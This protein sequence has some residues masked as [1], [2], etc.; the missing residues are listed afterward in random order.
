MF[1]NRDEELSFLNERYV[2][3]STGELIVIYGRRRVG[4]TELVRKFIST[5]EKSLYLYIDYASPLEV[6]D[7]ISN[8]ISRQ[9]GDFVRFRDWDTFYSY[10]SSRGGVVVI[11][12]F[13]RLFEIDK[14][15]VTRLQRIWDIEL[16]DKPLML[17]LVGSSIGMMRNA[18]LSGTAPL[19]GRV[20][21]TM[22]LQPL[23][24]RSFRYFFPEMDEVKKVQLYA[25]FGGTP[26]YLEFVKKYETED[27]RTIIHE[28]V[29]KKGAPLQNEPLNLLQME[30][31]EIARYNSIL[32]AISSG[33]HTFKEISD[34]SGIETSKISYYI[35]NLSRLLDLTVAADPVGGKKKSG[36]Y[37][38]KDNFFRF[39]YR[40]IFRNH[41]AL[42]VSTTDIV[43]NMIM[44]HLN[45]YLA[46]AFEDIVRELFVHYNGRTIKGHSIKFSTIGAWWNRTGDEI[47]ICA[48]GDGKMY[49][50]EVK[51]TNRQVGCN[52]AR[53]L[54]K[55]SEM[56]RGSGERIFMLV[57]RTGFTD[58]CIRYM[59][60]NN[61]IYLDLK[62][63]SALFQQS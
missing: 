44:E 2:N 41:A 5:I 12:E 19:Y 8:D 17:V 56:V 61:W 21:S 33:K 18:A 38:I 26:Y 54:V 48:S 6:L 9:S 10:L 25:I 51:W 16:K 30:L 11:D 58:K 4:K 55:K 32:S 50:G 23:D 42:E 57:S 43:M 47:D 49:L 63:I 29:L 60:E 31:K 35:D 40:F 59:D 20:T 45:N 52:V 62:D 27:I 37:A 15:A 24:Y 36:R 22:K 34:Y 14:K 46:F 3:L 39:W 7:I 53:Q 13:Q 1:Y 28:T